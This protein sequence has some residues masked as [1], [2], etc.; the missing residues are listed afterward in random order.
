MQQG[1]EAELRARFDV[2]EERFE[3]GDWSVDLILP[4]AADELID[5]GEFADDERLPYWAELWPSAR[6]LARH[7]LDASAG[8]DSDGGGG[9][10]TAGGGWGGARVLELGCG[11]ALPSL[12]LRSRGVDVLAT[13][14]YGDALRFAEVNAARNGLDPLRT[15]MLDWRHPPR[16]WGYDL[17]IAADVLYEP[18][19]VDILAALLGRVVAPGGTALVADPGRVYAGDFLR[20][21]RQQGWRADEADVRM[22]P[23]AAG[24][25]SRVRIHRLR[26]AE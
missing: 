16:G 18:R 19:N 22:E 5:E 10:G 3:H 2:R 15:E 23:S 20:T 8:G 12:A 4:R 7:L 24:A 14:W 13:D 9:Y 1:L 17:V 11:V 21:L 26:R 6:G 25:Q